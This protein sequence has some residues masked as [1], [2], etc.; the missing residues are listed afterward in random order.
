M[1]LPANFAIREILPFN[2]FAVVV[3]NFFV[4]LLFVTVFNHN[5]L[6]DAKSK[7]FVLMGVFI[8]I[9]VDFA[10]FARLVPETNDTG[11]AV[12]FLKIAWVA[13]PLLFYTT[14]L[15]SIHIIEASMTYR[16]MSRALLFMALTMGV[17]TATTD[18]TLKGV[19]YDPNGVLGR[20]L[21]IDYGIP[22]FYIFLAGIFAIM[23]F[24]LFPLIR[25]KLDDKSKVFLS[26]IVV[27][28]VANA[29]FNI[30]LPRLG[31]A[32]FYFFGDYSTIMLLSFTA[33][34]IFRHNLFDIKTFAT[35]LFILVIWTLLFTRVLFNLTV[36]DVT[37]LAIDTV[38]FVVMVFFGILLIKSVKTEIE[39]RQQLGVLNAKLQELDARKDEFLNVAAHELRAP[40][41]AIKGYLSMIKDGDAGQIS[42]RT[43]EF[44]GDAMD[45]NDRLIR[46]VNNMLNISRIEEGR[47]VYDIGIVDLNTVVETVFN[48][49]QID[50]K[51]KGLDYRFEGDPL[52]Q[53]PVEVD[54][55]RIHEVIGNLI[56]NAIKYTDQ[57]I[58]LV[59]VFKPS[60]DKVRVEISDTGPG[61]SPAEQQKIFQKFYRAE[62]TIGKQLGTG[63][64]LYVS[65][66]L[67]EKFGG[68]I[69]FQ[70]ELGKGTTFWFELPV[71]K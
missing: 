43:M 1:L 57:G 47:M 42:P 36:F 38:I 9:W 13:T 64:G 39:Q 22:G 44:L 15:T 12:I 50:A 41:T 5:Q 33:Y 24:T 61:I 58:V 25:R 68:K 48:D 35:E 34:A 26:G 53:Y 54:K 56:S 60:F 55:D 63:L 67:V 62:S 49:Y 65:K 10:H 6:R 71:K 32:D 2:N 23:I 27:F 51:Q 59:R 31:R 14:Y 28:Y 3:I 18:L 52:S 8:L 37:Q 46:L 29:I 66:L 40:M 21:I 17:I 20:T 30:A 7:L 70:S 45:G 19:I 69:G 11:L 4:L 16:N